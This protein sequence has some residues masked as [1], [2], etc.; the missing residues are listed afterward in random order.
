MLILYLL[1]LYMLILYKHKY[2]ESYFNVS[3][4]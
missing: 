4:P 1:I 3:F 2:K